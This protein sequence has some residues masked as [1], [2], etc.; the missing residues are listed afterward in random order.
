LKF[1]FELKRGYFLEIYKF[2]ITLN[3]ILKLQKLKIPKLYI[4]V[5]PTTLLFKTFS[6]YASILKL[7]WGDKK[8]SNLR[9]ESFQNY[10]KFCT[11]T[12]KTQN[13][14]LVALEKIYKL[15]FTLFPNLDFDLFKK[16]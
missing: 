5:R 9:F 2:K 4:Q 8:G 6:N 12:L 15:G 13:T 1:E 16:G 10:S 14:K 11:E 3:F 7:Y